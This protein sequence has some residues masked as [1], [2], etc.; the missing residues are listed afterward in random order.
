MVEAMTRVVDS[1]WWLNGREVDAFCEEFG[2][3][4]GV[5]HMLAVANGS[6]ALEIAMRAMLVKGGRAGRE[7]I[8]VANAG[9]YSSIACRIIGLVPVYVDIEPES[10]LMSLEAAVKSLSGETAFVVVTHLYGGMV[11]VAGLRAAM[12]EAGFGDVPIIEDCAQ[13]HGVRLDGRM[14]GSIGD[15]A[16]FSYYPTKNLGACG[17]AGAIATDNDELAAICRQL[18]QY[19]WS[20]KY[21]IGLAN[22]RNSRMDEVQAAVLRVMLPGL[23]AAN[24]RRVEILVRYEQSA[25]EGVKLVKSPHGTVGHLAVVTCRDRE[26]LRGHL[27][28]LGI[29]TDIHYPVLD[30]DQQAW[31]ESGWKEGAG[32]LAHSRA[33]RD[34]ILTLPC[35]PAMSDED[36]MRVCDALKGWKA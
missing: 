6:D 23:E 26:G 17:D 27:K 9:G 5:K 11:D 24:A 3:Y 29:M 30:C 35:Y 4:V 16:T 28:A 2:A 15:V 8:T 10:H 18:Q 14:A 31:K 1:G 19:G 13:A 32:G 25:P 34:S 36:V 22:G 21:S 20:S 12:D 33:A 7:V